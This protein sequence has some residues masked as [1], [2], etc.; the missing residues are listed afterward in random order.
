MM[1]VC[2]RMLLCIQLCTRMV[3]HV[4]QHMHACNVLYSY[5]KKVL[6]RGLRPAGAIAPRRLISA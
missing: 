2:V 3:M 1:R 5:N 4:G 6:P